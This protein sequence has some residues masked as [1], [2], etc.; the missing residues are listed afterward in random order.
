M[1]KKKNEYLNQ[2]EIKFK[3]V[4]AEIYERET[5]ILEELKRLKN[6]FNIQM[7][8]L[9]EELEELIETREKF[10][11]A[12]EKLQESD[13]DSWEKA[14]NVFEKEYSQAEVTRA[15]FIRQAEEKLELLAERLKELEVFADRA[16]KDSEKDFQHFLNDLNKEKEKLVKKLDEAREDSGEQWR[17]MKSWFSEQ[18]RKIRDSINQALSGSRK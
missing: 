4:M 7:E 13:D 18:S 12:Y 16:K 6:R 17:S 10:K 11:S 14:K 5:D 3:T 8:S 2:A 1:E 15:D 9:N